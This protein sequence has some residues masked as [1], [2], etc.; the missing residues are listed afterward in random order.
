M[1]G[2]VGYINVLIGIYWIYYV[3]LKFIG[4][5]GVI[6]DVYVSE[7]ISGFEGKLRNLYLWT[8]LMFI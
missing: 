3:L 7:F 1:L 5:G 6:K 4:G 8:E 2:E